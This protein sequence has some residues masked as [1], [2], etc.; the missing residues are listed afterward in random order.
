MA[1]QRED[2]NI[3]AD[4]PTIGQ[5]MS[6]A[7][8]DVA[9]A[10]AAKAILVP[11]FTGRTASAVARTTCA[12]GDRASW[13]CTS[14]SNAPDRTMRYRHGAGVTVTGV[15]SAECTRRR[16]HEALTASSKSH[17]PSSQKHQ[18]RS[19]GRSGPSGASTTV[20]VVEPTA[21]SR[22]AK[23]SPAAP[24]PTTTTS[25]PSPAGC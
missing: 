24:P 25:D 16:D 14:R 3:K 19:G 21:V 9:E 17:G 1:K 10:L 2:A 20:T 11:T 5:A 23:L 8:C 18:V 22:C 12:P 15:L 6:N 4:E 7:A 13:A